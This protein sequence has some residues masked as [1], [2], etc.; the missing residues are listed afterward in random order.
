MQRHNEPQRID[1]GNWYILIAGLPRP[2]QP[3]YLASGLSLRPLRSP[4]SVFDL[5]AAGAAGFREW[6]ILEPFAPICSCEIET[7]ADA[8][9]LPG[10]DTLNRA[11]LVSALLVLRGFSR[12]LA[13]ACSSYSWDMVAGHQERTSSVFHQ[14]VS[15]EGVESAVYRSKRDLPPFRGDIL[16]FHR[17]LLANDKPRQQKLSKEDMR[18]IQRHFDTFNQLANESDSFRFALEA[19]VSWRYSKEPRSAVAELWSGIEAIYGINQELVYRISLLSASLLEPRGESRKRRFL[20]IKRLYGLRS[21]VVHGEPLPEERINAAMR[22]SYNLLR[23]LLL[24]SVERGH[25]LGSNDFDQAM[26]E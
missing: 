2:D 23:S 17:Q 14:Q 10:Y 7:A 8:A 26:F 9:T 11:W 22:D 16:D 19:A 24:L 21:K 18:W 15:E 6:A 3:I 5:A 12:H 20:A 25:A 4:L 13:V 1:D